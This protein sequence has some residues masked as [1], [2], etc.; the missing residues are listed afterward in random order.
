VATGLISR[1]R[2]LPLHEATRAAK[3]ATL[4]CAKS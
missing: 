2:R 4:N 3:C 1:R